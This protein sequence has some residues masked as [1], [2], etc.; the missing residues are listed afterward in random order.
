MS[1]NVLPH[2]GVVRVCA[3]GVGGVGGG[4]GGP[5]GLLVHLVAQLGLGLQTGLGRVW[6]LL[7]SCSPRAVDLPAGGVSLA[8]PAVRHPQSLVQGQPFIA[9]HPLHLLDVDLGRCR[10]HTGVT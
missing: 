7:A 10:G 1:D 6:P 8:G 9:L 5:P 2:L 3:R 4:Q